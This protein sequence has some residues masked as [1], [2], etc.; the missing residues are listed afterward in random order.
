MI[1]PAV[2]VGFDLLGIA[3]LPG[4]AQLDRHI[5]ELDRAV[6]RLRLLAQEGVHAYGQADLNRGPATDA[7]HAYMTSPDGALP[8]AADLADRLTTAADGLRV[9]KGVIEWVVGPLSAVALAARVAVVFA[10]HLLPRLSAMGAR[11]TAML[12]DALSRVGRIFASLFKTSRV[13]AAGAGGR[14]ARAGPKPDYRAVAANRST[15]VDDVVAEEL[16]R[17]GNRWRTENTPVYHGSRTSPDRIFE[18]G[19]HPYVPGDRVY[20]SL[21]SEIARWYA[22]G[23]FTYRVRT[24]RGGG[25]ARGDS[26]ETVTFP[27]GVHRRFVEGA[28]DHRTGDFLPNPHFDPG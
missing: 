6:G 12:R 2:L 28:D 8:Q 18:E 26:E 11:F 21:D 4:T 27:G 24:S 16:R 20:T 7:L 3:P 1:E 17:P 15:P 19:L 25:F 9:S 22:R 10:P 13:R 23:R 5:G 14:T